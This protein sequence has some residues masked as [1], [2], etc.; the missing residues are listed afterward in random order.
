VIGALGLLER[1]PPTAVGRIPGTCRSAFLCRLGM[2]DP[3]T[4]Q[5]VGF[6]R[7]DRRC[8]VG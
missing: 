5:L 2:N 6:E 8:S 1:Y 4:V 3:P 7:A